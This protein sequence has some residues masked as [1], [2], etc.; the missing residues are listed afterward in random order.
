MADYTT[1][2]DGTT[3]S[4]VA[5]SNAASAPAR[6]VLVGEFD[7]GRRNLAAADTVVVIDI[8]PNTYVEQVFLDVITIDATQTVDV[9]D[10]DS[11]DGWGEDLSLATAGLVHDVD[12]D[13]NAAAAQAGKL[14]K[15][16]GVIKLTVPVDKALDTA[17]FRVIAPVTLL[18]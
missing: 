17:K 2:A 16:G 13:F 7:A 15:T 8:P 18:G 4:A 12:A 10:G 6:T 14:Y 9:G 5:G 3:V 1:Y 11:V